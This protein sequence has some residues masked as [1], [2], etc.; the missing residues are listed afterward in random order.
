MM[1]DARKIVTAREERTAQKEASRKR[2]VYL[3]G[4]SFFLYLWFL[5]INVIGQAVVALRHAGHSAVA[6]LDV[7]TSLS[8]Y[9]FPLLGCLVFLWI[10]VQVTKPVAA[11]G[12][13][14]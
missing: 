4:V 12:Q 14:L 2:K 8:F 3:F 9:A 13:V 7:V 10:V 6:R 1:V 11:G 5:G